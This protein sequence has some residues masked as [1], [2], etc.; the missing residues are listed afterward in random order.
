MRQNILTLALLASTLFMHSCKNKDKKTNKS[1]EIVVHM[2]SDADIWFCHTIQ[3]LPMLPIKN[4]WCF[5]SWLIIR[6]TKQANLLESYYAKDRPII[7]PITSWEFKGGMKS[8]MRLDQKQNGTME[9]LLQVMMSYSLL[10]VYW[11]LKQIMKTLNHTTAGWG[12]PLSILW[13]QKDNHV[14]QR[15]I[16]F[17][18]GIQRLLIFQN[19]YTIL[20]KS[21]ADSNIIDM[22]TSEKRTAL[23]GNPAIQ[24][25][26]DNL[27]WEKFQREK[28]FVVRSAL[29]VRQMD[30]WSTHR[31]CKKRQMVGRQYKS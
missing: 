16:H 18:W 24:K 29:S 15:K 13:I 22:N 27:N 20:R 7:T 2:L 1:S 11:I 25:F 10:N 5:K 4:N 19:T 21:C 17:S 26:A 8:S 14:L 30:N 12:M 23:K 3:L 6:N 9:V 31:L 28:G